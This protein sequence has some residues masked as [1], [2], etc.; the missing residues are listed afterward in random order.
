MNTAYCD[1]L[2]NG[3]C[4]IKFIPEKSL[5]LIRYIQFLGKMEGI[6]LKNIF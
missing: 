3:Q 1:T 6:L 4:Q 2:K 5:H